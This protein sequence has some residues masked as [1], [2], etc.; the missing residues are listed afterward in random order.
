VPGD[1]PVIDAVQVRSG[2]YVDAIR[3]HYYYPNDPDNLY[4]G[5]GAY[6]SQWYGPTNA[7]TLRTAFWCPEGEGLTRYFIWPYAGR[8]G[9][10]SFS[11]NWVDQENGAYAP[12]DESPVWGNHGQTIYLGAWETDELLTSFALSYDNA[13]LTGFRGN[14]KAK[15]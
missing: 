6:W 13:S 12:V 4:H 11:C 5:Q 1:S 15:W 3:F 7:G 8:I 9:A 10:I 14:C 2:D